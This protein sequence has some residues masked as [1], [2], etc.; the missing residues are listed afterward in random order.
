MSLD[1]LEPPQ[2]SPLPCGEREYAEIAAGLRDTI[3]A[4]QKMGL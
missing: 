3:T 4:L 1:K 2:P